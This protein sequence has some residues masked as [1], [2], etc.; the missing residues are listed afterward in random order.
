[1]K[2]MCA[3]FAL[4]VGP[5]AVEMSLARISECG[6]CCW[7]KDTVKGTRTSQAFSGRADH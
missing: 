2:N 1:M 4:A 5:G 7:V 3:W 6:R